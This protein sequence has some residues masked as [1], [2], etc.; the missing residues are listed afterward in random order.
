MPDPPARATTFLESLNGSKQNSPK[1]RCA[2][3]VAEALDIPNVR[4]FGNRLKTGSTERVIK[5]ISRLCSLSPKVNILLEVHGD[6]NTEEAL[7][8]VV[9]ALGHFKNFGLIWDIEHTHKPYGDRWREFYATLRPYIKHVHIKD[10]TADTDELCLIGDGSIPVKEICSQLLSDGY[11][12]YFSLEWEK[13]WHPELP[14]IE[15][16]LD[17]FIQIMREVEHEC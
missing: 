13:K 10:R 15:K 16:A 8:P 7:S 14:E 12:G 6:Y 3:K 2:V 1:G 11:E 17:S 5:G 4:V 9:E